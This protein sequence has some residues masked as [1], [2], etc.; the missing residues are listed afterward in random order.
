ML[1]MIL[2]P[3]SWEDILLGLLLKVGG[4]N[5]GCHVPS[6][7]RERVGEVSCFAYPGGTLDTH[8]IYVYIYI[9]IYIGFLGPQCLGFDQ[10]TTQQSLA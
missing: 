7:K 4:M 2:R 3:P 5:L 6:F 1:H 8:I 10:D 9:Y